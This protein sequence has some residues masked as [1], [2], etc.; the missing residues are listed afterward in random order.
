MS[1]CKRAGICAVIVNGITYW[2][3]RDASKVSV[4]L[5]VAIKSVLEPEDI[6]SSIGVFSNTTG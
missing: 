5:A 4:M 2:T 1:I 6:C 3:A